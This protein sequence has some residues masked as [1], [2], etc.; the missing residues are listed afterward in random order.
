[1][2]RRLGAE[3]TVF[4]AETRLGVDNGTENELFFVSPHDFTCTVQDIDR[5]SFGKRGK[6]AC[7]IILNGILSLMDNLFCNPANVHLFLLNPAIYSAV[8]CG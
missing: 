4:R 2:V 6:L 5:I 8:S 7:F 3:S 1:M